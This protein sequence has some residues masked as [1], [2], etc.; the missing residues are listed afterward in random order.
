MDAKKF[1]LFI[2]KIRKEKNMTQADLAKKLHV[3]D[4]AICRWKRGFGFPYIY[5]R[6][7]GGRFRIKCA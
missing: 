1:A 7:V 5:N 3:T 2:T 4:K 6:A